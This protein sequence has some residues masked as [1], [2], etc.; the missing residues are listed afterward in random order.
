MRCKFLFD[1]KVISCKAAVTW[2]AKEPLTIEMVEEAPPKAHEVRIRMIR[3][4]RC[5]WVAL[6]K[7]HLLEAGVAS[8]TS[9]N[10]SMRTCA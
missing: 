5:V 10:W 3:L 6:G 8:T 4:T 7:A 2:V 1:I 9:R